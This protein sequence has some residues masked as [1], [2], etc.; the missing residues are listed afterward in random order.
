MSKHR[1]IQQ[2]LNRY[3]DAVNR[4]DWTAFAAVYAEDAIW[5]GQGD[6]SMRFEGRDAITLGFVSIIEPMS[7]FVQMNA[8]AVIEIDGDRA[9]A[10]STIH[11]LGDVPVEGT[12]FELYGRYEDELVRHKGEWLFHHRR[13]VPV[14]RQVSPIPINDWAFRP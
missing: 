11:E 13:F 2:Q 3:T 10:R 12:R 4:R 8:P 5:E 7:M 9:K 6:L 1:Q 14:T